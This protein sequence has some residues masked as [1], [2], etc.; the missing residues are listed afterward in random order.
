[1]TARYPCYTFS[2][3]WFLIG[4]IIWS[5]KMLNWLLQRNL[6]TSQ[7]S[8]KQ[9]WYS[10][11]LSLG[12]IGRHNCYRHLS[13]VSLWANQNLRCTCV[14]WGCFALLYCRSGWRCREIEC[15]TNPGCI[16]IFL[17]ASPEVSFNTTGLLKILK[18]GVILPLTSIDS[19]QFAE[20]VVWARVN[21]CHLHFNKGSTISPTLIL[22]LLLKV[23][24]YVRS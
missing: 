17:P 13:I 7:F 2:N 22:N 10:T 18:G 16:Q 21:Q 14:K 4:R 20:R 24:I 15:Q 9:L 8:S 11:V 3:I 23:T 1:M 5:K 12:Q 6:W 19:L